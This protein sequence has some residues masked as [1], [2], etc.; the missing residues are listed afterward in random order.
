MYRTIDCRIHRDKKFRG[1]SM[2]ASWL[3]VYL[4]TN[5][6]TNVSGCY[7]L[8]DCTVL[9]E[10][11]MDS[12][13][14][15]AALAE[16]LNAEMVTRDDETQEFFVVNFLR[17]QANSP[18]VE[19]GAL[20]KVR[21]IESTGIK[22][23]FLISYP[24]FRG[25]LKD[26]DLGSADM[27][28][29]GYLDGTHTLPISG[30]GTGTG[31]G[32]DNEDVI[33]CAARSE[34]RAAP[35]EEPA[36]LDVFMWAPVSGKRKFPKGYPITREMIA[37]YRELYP[38]VDV[39]AQVRAAVGWSEA[40]EKRRKTHGGYARHLNAWISKAQNQGENGNEPANGNGAGPRHESKMEKYDRMHRE[41]FD[42]AIAEEER[43]LAGRT[44]DAEPP[45]H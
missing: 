8:P 13:G 28:S 40:N 38:G 33:S 18:R 23:D 45:N 9:G 22:R 24:Q 19:I 12:R 7:Y 27:V 16:L 32:T 44:F 11:K 31:T 30:T 20:R 29:K 35:D 41:Y 5:E 42:R 14:Y 2:P 1:L 36:D 43:E 15:R 37:R 26:L 17:Y 10:A 34:H 39:E 6:H 4:L 3:F 25:E 21:D